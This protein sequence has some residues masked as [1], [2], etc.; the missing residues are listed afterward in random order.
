MRPLARSSGLQMSYSQGLRLGLSQIANPSAPSSESMM[1][2]CY[3][4]TMYAGIRAITSHR[5]VWQ[6]IAI[7][8]CAAGMACKESMVTV[9]S[10]IAT[11]AG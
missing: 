2:L 9:S 11:N 6:T 7:V 10:F 8:S 1:A 5:V 3:L 4:L